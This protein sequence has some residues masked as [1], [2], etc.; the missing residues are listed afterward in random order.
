MRNTNTPARSTARAGSATARKLLLDIKTGIA[1]AA[2]RYQL[3]A[4]APACRIH[5]PGSGVAWSCIRTAAIG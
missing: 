1:P 2:V 4:I 5:A 3:A